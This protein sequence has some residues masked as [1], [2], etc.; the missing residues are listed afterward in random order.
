M[1][2]EQTSLHKKISQ[3]LEYRDSNFPVAFE[4]FI[5]KL[6]GRS[7]LFYGAGAFGQENFDLF[8][9]YGLKP[10][11]FLDRS[12][13]QNE[14][15]NGIPVFQPDSKELPDKL[16]SECSVFISITLPKTKIKAIKDGLSL[17]GY[18]NVSEI[19]KITAR[20]V[21]YDGMPDEN[22]GKDYLDQ[23]RERIFHAASL[24]ADDESRETYLS[25]ISA[26]LL[27]D[28]ETCIETDFPVQYFD[29]GV[30]YTKGLSHFID[31]G[32]YT[33][34]SLKTALAFTDKITH[35]AAFEPIL[36]NYRILSANLD[37]LADK[38][39]CANL[40]PCGVSDKTSIARFTVSA[41]SSTMTDTKEGELL[42]I[43]SIDD[44][45]KGFPVTFLKMDIEGAELAA[46][47]GAE[48]LIRRFK[49]DMAI[50]VYHA[51]NHFW[52]IPCM[53]D[54]FGAGY[55]FYLRAHTPATLET[56]LYAISDKK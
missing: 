56:V 38:I 26:H 24:M 13:K 43:I 9:H 1:N 33:G 42:P 17:L 46:L 21:K 35:Y 55:K 27:R 54:D 45:L 3:V 47:R 16:R 25:S 5:R 32:A 8:S 6:D 11:A 18:N 53:I 19:Q 39:A 31:C 51:V 50:S 49:P 7:F 2:F 48:H 10:V 22:P 30:P 34:D 37:L 40:F 4:N 36:A 44:A 29:A 23:N 12:A 41:S 20:Q 14:T 52:D 15:K 28:Y